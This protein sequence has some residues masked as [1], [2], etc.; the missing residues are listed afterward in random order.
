MS[1]REKW[2]ELLL[3]EKEDEERGIFPRWK[4]LV[5]AYAIKY[6][7]EELVE[8]SNLPEEVKLCILAE[9]KYSEYS[10]D[11]MEFKYYQEE[12]EAETL[13]AI[14]RL[15][16]CGDCWWV[17]LL[18]I[19][20]IIGSH[21]PTC[22][23]SNREKWCELLLQEKED[24][25]R[26]IFPRWKE[27]VL[28]YAIKYHTEELVESSN[29]PEEV[30]LCILAELK[31]SEYSFDLM[32]FEYYQKEEE[33]ETLQ[34]IRR[35]FE[36]AEE[37]GESMED[38]SDTEQQQQEDRQRRVRRRLFDDSLTEHAASEVSLDDWLTEHVA[39]LDDEALAYL[40]MKLAAPEVF[41]APE[42]SQEDAALAYLIY[43]LF[44]H[45]WILSAFVLLLL[46]ITK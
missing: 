34:A 25:E 17:L 36:C 26:G 37:S 19:M 9:L 41:A 44:I 42:V 43:Y 28:A 4:E 24:E 12:E 31:Y 29:L 22:P 14:R 11:L 13:Q 39:S 27:L 45:N 18:M 30:K 15:F 32:A 20:F 23:L 5:L 40:L 16:E 1:N 3:Q 6:H 10:F 33:A 2:C 7:T 21:N 8:S 38:D 46:F 35:L